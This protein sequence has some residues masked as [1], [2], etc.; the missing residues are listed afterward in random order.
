MDDYPTPG[1]FAYARTVLD[2]LVEALVRSGR[3]MPRSVAPAR[4]VLDRAMTCAL[5][6]GRQANSPDEAE[7]ASGKIGTDGVAEM[8]G[9]TRRT[10]QRNAESL[11]ARR[12]SGT[13][14]FDRDDIGA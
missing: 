9:V 3:P 2:G 4:A 10:A 11:G 13:W 6:L 12:V 5:S 8:L 7:S 1:D 14:V